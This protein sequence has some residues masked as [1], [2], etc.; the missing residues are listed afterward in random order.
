MREEKVPFL[1]IKGRSAG[2]AIQA[3]KIQDRMGEYY[4][5]EMPR[6]RQN[7]DLMKKMSYIGGDAVIIGDTKIWTNSKV[8][9]ES[10]REDLARQKGR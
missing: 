9:K 1:V 10:L 8:V 6:K 4:I 3:S 2:R 7:V 5:W